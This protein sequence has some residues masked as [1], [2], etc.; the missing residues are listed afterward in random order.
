MIHTGVSLKT[1]DE[2]ISNFSMQVRCHDCL[3]VLR[4]N[5]FIEITCIN[6]RGGTID[7]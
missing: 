6:A 5:P 3:A 4:L 2:T 1:L 7:N